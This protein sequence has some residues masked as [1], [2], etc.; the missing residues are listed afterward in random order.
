MI[1]VTVVQADVVRRGGVQT[2]RLRAVQGGAGSAQRVIQAVVGRVAGDPVRRGARVQALGVAAVGV[3][4]K[5]TPDQG[6]GRHV[7]FAYERVTL[8]DLDAG[9]SSKNSGEKGRVIGTWC[10]GERRVQ[11]QEPCVRGVAASAFNVPDRGAI[12]KRLDGKEPGNLLAM[13]VH[14]LQ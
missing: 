1:L 7:A 10:P 2:R 3:R 12:V 9:C 5:T 14:V 11:R 13:L 4:V 6:V 8:E